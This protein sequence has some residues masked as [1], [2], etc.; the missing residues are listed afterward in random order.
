MNVFLIKKINGM[1]IAITKG[2]ISARF[3]RIGIRTFT[4]PL[5]FPSFRSIIFKDRNGRRRRIVAF[6]LN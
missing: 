1:I 6:F 4:T 5:R 3:M 2:A